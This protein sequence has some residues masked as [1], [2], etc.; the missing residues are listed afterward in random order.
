MC[1][2][3]CNQSLIPLIKYTFSWHNTLDSLIYFEYEAVQTFSLLSET[4]I[5]QRVTIMIKIYLSP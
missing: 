1:N 2:K 4:K 3:Q 5:D